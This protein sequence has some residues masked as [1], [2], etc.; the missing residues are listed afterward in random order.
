MLDAVLVA[1]P[2][3]SRVQPEEV[4]ITWGDQ[5]GVLPGTV[6]RLADVMGSAKRPAAALPT[7][8]RADPYI[9]FDRD[10]GGRL[11]ALRQRRE[12]DAMPAIG[13]SDMGLFGLTRRSYERE[14]T[15]Y[16]ATVPPGAATG[17][18]NFVPFM[19]WLAGRAPVETFPCTDEREAIGINT[20]EELRLMEAWLATRPA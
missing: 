17:E 16:A 14:L 7:V 13:E 15:E 8:M 20:P 18:R 4:W 2:V 5:V 6:E 11:S 19:A 3:V 1:S 9:H 10:A 12:G